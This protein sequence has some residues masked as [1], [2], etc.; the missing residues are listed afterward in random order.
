MTTE[1]TSATDGGPGF[2]GRGAAHAAELG[3]VW[4]ACGADS[5]VGPLRR[6]L[7]ARP[8]HTLDAVHDPEAWH[9]LARPDRRAI[10]SAAAA[11]AATYQ[12]LGVGVDWIDAPK[13]PPNLL[14]ARDLFVMTPEG[15]VL[16]RM[17]AQ[18]R[19]GE[20]RACAAALSGLGVP[21]LATPRGRET[22]EG[23]D[24][25]FLR[26]VVLIGVGLR[27][28][29]AGAARLQGVLADQGIDSRQVPMPAAGVQHLLGVVTPVDAAR[30]LLRTARATDGI[31]G[32]LRDLGLT[33]LPLPESPELVVGRGANLV[34][35]RPGEVVMPAA[36]ALQA[37][38]EALGVRC[39]PVRMDPYLA[40]AGGVACAT[41]IL[42]RAPVS[43]GP[44]PPA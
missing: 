44:L 30:V 11:L 25:L 36:P 8:P 35:V 26:G 42:H 23:A 34:A 7:L 1:P 6:V 18:V 27:T 39:H 37:R 2:R 38:L 9:M 19:A 29:R 4:G 31:R 17:G 10:A 3:T 15:A 22:L 12:G 28:N 5:E 32:A 21:L 43:A 33:A 13:A 20:E 14:F 41:G 40:A 16:A 24:A